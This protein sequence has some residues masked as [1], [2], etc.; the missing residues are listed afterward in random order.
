MQDQHRKAEERLA[1]ENA[2]LEQRAAEL[3]AARAKNA[4]LRKSAMEAQVRDVHA[5]LCHMA[6]MDC[7][8]T[9]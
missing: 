6:A 7:C 8:M 2:Q 5:M 3:E 4:E 9:M 1:V